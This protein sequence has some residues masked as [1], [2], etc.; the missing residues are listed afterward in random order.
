[1]S[2]V[3][4]RSDHVAGAMLREY[5][6]ILLQEVGLRA[7]ARHLRV[8]PRRGRGVAPSTCRGVPPT[9][10]ERESSAQA[11]TPAAGSVGPQIVHAGEERHLVFGEDA[12]QSRMRVDDPYALVAPYTRQMMSFL[13][14]DP[15]PAH[16]LLIGL[17]GGSLAKFCYRYL[18]HARVT[19]VEIDERVIALRDSFHVPPD[20]ERFQIVHGDGARYVAQLDHPVDAILIDAFDEGGV[21]PALMTSTFFEHA[22]QHLAPTG[23]LIM[24]LHGNPA[25]FTSQLEHAK[26]AFEDRALLAAV[27]GSDNVLLCAFAPDASSP[28]SPHVFLRARHLQSKLRLN[29][30]VY[31]QR[32]REGRRL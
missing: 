12:L 10:P 5:L 13:L 17:G 27:T 25:R 15:D 8:G 32:M 7:A 19:V 26:V 3:H 2:W 9:E 11:S 28:G 4:K 21:S 30:R 18:P 23:V 1:M 31:L 6:A 29:F 20:D 16:V 14:F 22:A 24:N